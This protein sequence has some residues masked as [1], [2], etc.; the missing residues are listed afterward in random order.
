M[1]G[2]S[3]SFFTAEKSAGVTNNVIPQHASHQDC[4][5]NNIDNLF[6]L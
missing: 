2:V 5:Q 3:Q 1:C 6:Y 4:I